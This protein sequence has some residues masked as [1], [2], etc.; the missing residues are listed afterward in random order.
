M[1]S[2]S[3]LSTVPSGY[4][5]NLMVL[6]RT[7]TAIEAQWSTV[8]IDERNGDIIFY[9]VELNQSM[10]TEELSSDLR[11]TNGSQLILLL[12]DLE[13]FVE[14]TVRVRANA[15]AGAGPFSPHVSNQTLTDSEW[16]IYVSVSYMTYD[17]MYTSLY[18]ASNTSGECLSDNTVLY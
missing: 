12:S 14:Y 3:L 9:E 7:S 2:F 6:T 16:T 15:S 5:Q 1:I 17:C 13:E 4:P 10:F 8:P 11:Q 18:R